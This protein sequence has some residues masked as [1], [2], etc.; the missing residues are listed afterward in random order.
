MFTKYQCITVLKNSELAVVSHVALE[1]NFDETNTAKTKRFLGINGLT[2]QTGC[3]SLSI[4]L[5]GYSTMEEDPL[6]RSDTAI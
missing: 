1:E 6:Y 2:N 3:L 5:S 4:V